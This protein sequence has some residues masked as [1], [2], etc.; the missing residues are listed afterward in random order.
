[1]APVGG[2]HVFTI[3]QMGTIAGYQ[4]YVEGVVGKLIFGGDTNAYV[5]IRPANGSS[6]DGDQAATM[7][8]ALGGKSRGNMTIPKRA[9]A[10]IGLVGAFIW[11]QA[12]DKSGATHDYAI[13]LKAAIL[14]YLNTNDV[15]TAT[16]TLIK[17]I[18][19]EIGGNS[20]NT[21][22]TVNINGSGNTSGSNVLP[23]DGDN[24]PLDWGAVFASLTGSSGPITLDDFLQ[25]VVP[26]IRSGST[27][28]TGTGSLNF[29]LGGNTASLKTFISA[30]TTFL[31]TLDTSGKPSLGFLSHIMGFIGNDGW[32]ATFTGMSQSGIYALGLTLLAGALK[33]KDFASFWGSSF[34]PTE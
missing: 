17:A 4:K 21:V 16:R 13:D 11:Y 20:G 6:G 30:I 28:I 10:V 33:S 24:I 15:T 34:S 31:S 14:T 3:P 18:A 26:K 27:Y 32:N 9:L 1:M 5:K 22:S 12:K 8:L 2:S 25:K 29:E 7:T 23:V 19:A